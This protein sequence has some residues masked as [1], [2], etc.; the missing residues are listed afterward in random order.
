MA[1][2]ATAGIVGRSEDHGAGGDRR[3]GGEPSHLDPEAK[4]KQTAE[5]KKAARA[6]KQKQEAQVEQVGNIPSGPQKAEAIGK[7]TAATKSDPKA[8]PTKEDKQKALNE[9]AKKSSGQ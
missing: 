8:L 6:A 7:N 1:T 2:F 9:Q 5:E 4:A 3:A